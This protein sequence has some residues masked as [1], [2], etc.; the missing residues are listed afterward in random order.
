LRRGT[1][2]RSMVRLA[3]SDDCVGQLEIWRGT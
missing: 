1:G 3:S 2:V